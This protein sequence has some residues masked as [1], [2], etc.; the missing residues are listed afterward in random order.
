MVL[1]LFPGFLLGIGFAL[2][3][4]S[5]W[6]KTGW[7]APR[8]SRTKGSLGW[9]FHI[10]GNLSGFFT[11]FYF[12]IKDGVKIGSTQFQN[13]IKCAF[14]F[15]KSLSS[16]FCTVLRSNKQATFVCPIIKMVF[17][18]SSFSSSTFM[19]D[20]LL[21]KLSISFHIFERGPIH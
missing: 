11:T 5:S 20:L 19:L 10:L 2:A 12:P 17:S 9:R 3:E 15:V 1:K 6:L 21:C 8:K 18:I 14:I 13:S 16:Q 7:S 4:R